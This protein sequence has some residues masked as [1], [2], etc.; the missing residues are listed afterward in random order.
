MSSTQP[1]LQRTAATLLAKA[2]AVISESL[3]AKGGFGKIPV[4]SLRPR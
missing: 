4:G 3:W 2:G 1:R